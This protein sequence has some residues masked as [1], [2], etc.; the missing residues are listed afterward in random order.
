VPSTGAS[1]QAQLVFDEIASWH[2]EGARRVDVHSG[3]APRSQ[4]ARPARSPTRAT[5]TVTL[6]TL[7]RR[8]PRR[9]DQQQ[10]RTPEE[11][12]SRSSRRGTP[13]SWG[14][15]VWRRPAVPTS[16]PAGRQDAVETCRLVGAV[17]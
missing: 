7:R 6:P 17:D 12:P 4:P 5:S 13:T 9:A 2:G 11:L 1:R 3:F 10:G 16:T 8:Q 14:L 15:G